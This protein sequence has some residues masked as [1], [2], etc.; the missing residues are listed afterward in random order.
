MQNVTIRARQDAYG[1]TTHDIVTI[2]TGYAV[3]CDVRNIDEAKRIARSIDAQMD[4][5]REYA[6]AG[7]QPSVYL[8]A[9]ES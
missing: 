5:E 7:S 9:S 2:G 1:M 6:A 3:R 8:P 4:A